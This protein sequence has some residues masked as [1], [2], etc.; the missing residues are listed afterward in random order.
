MTGALSDT[1]GRKETICDKDKHNLQ[2]KLYF[3]SVREW[4]ILEGL[5]II[6]DLCRDKK[7][8]MKFAFLVEEFEET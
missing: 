3:L 7:L 6:Y 5:C 2:V 4:Y 1:Q 8:G